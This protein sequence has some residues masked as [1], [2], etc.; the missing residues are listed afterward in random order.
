MFKSELILM[1]HSLILEIKKNLTKD[2]LKEKYIN[3]NNDND[4]YGHC[5]VATEA[6][7]HMLNDNEKNNHI[8]QILKVG[9]ITHWF[10]KNKKT[11]EI[12]DITKDQFKF[13]L[14]YNKS[15]G[16]GFL[17]KNPSKRCIK[18][19]NKIKYNR[20]KKI[21]VDKNIFLFISIDD[22]YSLKRGDL[23]TLKNDLLCEYDNCYIYNY[24]DLKKHKNL[25]KDKLNKLKK[26]NQK[27][28]HARKCNIEVI[29][30]N[31]KNDFLKKNHIQGSDKS[32][33]SYGAY[34]NGELISVMTFDKNK[35]VNG[36]L[37]ENVY[38]LSRFS[39]KTNY[40]VNGIF[41]KILKVFINDYS[42]KK[43]ISFGDLNY[44]NKEYNIYTYNNFKLA[45]TT[46]PDFKYYNPDRDDIFHKITYGNLYVKRKNLS[47]SE[48]EKLYKKLVKVWDCGKLKYELYLNENKKP[49][50]GF[51]YKITNCVNNKI[52]I[53]QTTRNL[54]RR[55]SEYKKS[56]NQSYSH[57][58]PHLINSF[59]K[60]RFENFKFDIIDT[61]L[62]IDE[63]NE[64]EIFYIKKYNSTNKDVGYNLE[65]GG[66]N[67]I[68]TDDTKI[69]MSNSHRGVKQTTN[70]I[71][72][73]IAKAGT[74]EAKKY[75]RAKTKKE[76]KY[77]S[78][79]SPKYW[80][81]KKRS[82]N[83]KKKISETKKKNG[84]SDI[85]KD[86]L[87]KKVVAYNPLNNDIITIYESTFD[88]SKKIGNLSQSTISRRC[89]GKS[90]NRGSVYFKYL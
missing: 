14:N 60:Y 66:K 6:Y 79:N 54:S 55:I 88:A 4:M 50:F 85:Q 16:V 23:K 62:T 7:Y 83:T 15:K 45:N 43:I 64:K 17:T 47:K 57:N 9:D 31:T 11:G 33:I 42:P 13:S 77:L 29:S 32:Q 67:S 65:L 2:L 59:I 28:I 24:Y 10:L 82:E 21:I 35:K 34:Y 41:N 71:N 81:Y 76:K 39:I 72:N 61:A 36:G 30:L 44:V 27:I 22:F 70:W 26:S 38:D 75:G 48:K 68:V 19:I 86:K 80:K 18:L 89:S 84:L 3:K 5:Y 1:E 49:I 69:K 20:F 8:P 25:I 56:I 58:N 52:Y 46:P 74:E 90:K 63:L 53:G 78:E 37:K 40:V 73:R 51:I 12:I 87:C